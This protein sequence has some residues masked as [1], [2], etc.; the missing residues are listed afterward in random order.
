MSNH[1]SQL[2]AGSLEYNGPRQ[3]YRP[4]PIVLAQATGGEESGITVHVRLPVP[5]SQTRIKLS[6]VFFPQQ[7]DALGDISLS[8]SI[9]VSANEED[10]GGAAGSAGRSVPVT[11]VEQ[12][13]GAAT[14]FPL[15]SGLAGYSREFVTSADWLEADIALARSIQSG[16]W[17]LQTSIQPDSITFEWSAWDQIRRAFQPQVSG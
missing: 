3:F 7:G 10:Q 2:Q 5:S 6:V 15:F 12:T 9:L 8:G 17:V 16:F 11:Y 1:Q 4:A 14:P 13:A